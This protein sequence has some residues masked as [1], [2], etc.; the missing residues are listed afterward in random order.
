MMFVLMAALLVGAVTLTVMQI[1]TADLA[2]GLQQQEADQVFNIAQAG[3]HYAIGQLQVAGANSYAG[4]T[5]AITSG[6]TTLGTATITVNCIDTVGTAPPC[7]GTWAG[8]RRIISTG[9]LP[10]SGPSRTIVAVVQAT[11]GSSYGFCAGSAFTV[12]SESGSVYGDVGSNGTI[13]VPEGGHIY[14]DTNTPPAYNGNATSVANPITCDV[15]TNSM[16]STMIDGTITPGAPGPVCPSVTLPPFSPGSVDQTVPAGGWTMNTTTGYS[17]RNITVP[18]NLPASPAPAAPTVTPI[19]VTGT[20]SYRYAVVAEQGSKRTL[21]SPSTS[22]SNGNAVLNPFNYNV[23]SWAAVSGATS[24]DVLR[25]SGSGPYTYNLIGSTSST[26]LLDTG[27]AQTPY[28]AYTCSSYTDLKIDTTSGTPNPVVQVNT[29]TMGY[30]TRL[31]I[32]GAGTVDLRIGATTL[33]GLSVATISGDQTNNAALARFGVAST[34]TQSSPVLIPASQLLVSV[35]SNS[36][37]SPYAAYFNGADYISGTFFVPNGAFYTTYLR[38]KMYGTVAA[39]TVSLLGSGNY[40]ESGS[41]GGAGSYTNFTNL[42][43]W[44]DQ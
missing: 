40:Y 37:S 27:Q 29:L 9:S 28:P 3:V 26:A 43:S 17:W 14:K 24:Y 39:N 36:T 35:Y 31:M 30:C 4:G 20:T 25:V 11:Q 42:R 7:T 15:G 8:Y 6:S 18:D 38:N 10:V 13:N 22:I 23:I 5:Q 1:L 33:S 32:L 21:I 16:C 41:G 12:G 19:G 2:G 34:D 44:K